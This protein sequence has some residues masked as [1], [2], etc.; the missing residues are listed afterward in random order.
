MKIEKEHNLSKEEAKKRIDNLLLNLEK[1]HKDKISNPVTKWDSSNSKM[2]FSVDIYQDKITGFVELK[3]KLVIL[4]GTLPM[5]YM[6][7][8]GTIINIIDQTLTKTLS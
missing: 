3:E 8:K 6:F 1:E 5:K 4:E 2:E 7:F